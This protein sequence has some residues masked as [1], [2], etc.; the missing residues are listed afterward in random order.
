MSLTESFVTSLFDAMESHALASGMFDYVNKHE[1][2]N[3]PTGLSA[4]MWMQRFAPA[5]AKSGLASTTLLVVANV[6]TRIPATQNSDWIDPRLT[7]ATNALYDA[8][9]G[10]FTLGGLVRNVDLLGE[11]GT[12]LEAVAGWLPQET[13][14]R[15]YTVTVPM[16]VN[17]QH[18][19][20]P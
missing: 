16:I 1:S 6:R 13:L 3:P 14:Y 20:A 19:Q 2:N 9:S 7:A 10:D 15:V 12:A 5:R 11:S 8:Y 18:T 17:D 4:E